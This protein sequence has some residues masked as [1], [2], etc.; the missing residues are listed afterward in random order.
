MVDG[1]RHPLIIKG[2]KIFNRA[3]ST[4]YNQNIR[5]LIAIRI[6]NCCHN[7]LRRLSALYANWQKYNLA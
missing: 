3:A 1:I 2:P 5:K 6:A 4:S 7:L